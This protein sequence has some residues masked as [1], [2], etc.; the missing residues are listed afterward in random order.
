MQIFTQS[1]LDPVL[2]KG[3]YSTIINPDLNSMKLKQIR[4]SFI[5]FRSSSKPGALEG[6]AND[7]LILDEYDRVPQAAEASAL[8]GM[9]SSPYK[10]TN[11][12]STPSINDVGIHKLFKQSDQNYYMHKCPHCNY[13]NKMSFEP[14]VPEAPVEK[15]GNV[16]TVNP[17][18]V[19]LSAKT[20]VDGSFQYVCQKCGRPLDRW[21]TGEW[22]PMY[23]DRAKNNQGTRGYYIS[24]MNAVWI[25]LDDLK[26][27]ELTAESKQLFYNY[28]IG[29]PFIDAKMTVN[30]SDIMNHIRPDLNKQ[31]ENRQ[32]YAFVSVGVDFGNQ[33]SITIHGVRP[34]GVVDMIAN[35]QVAK[36]NPLNPDSIGTDIQALRVK[37]APYDPDIIVADIGDSGDKIAKL[38]QIYGKGKVYGCI[39]PS[40]PKS[41]GNV[42]PTWSENNNTV[43]ADKLMQNKRYIAKL[44][45]GEIGF[46]RGMDK[47]LEDFVSHWSNVVIRD[48]E[49][50]K[51]ITGFVQKITRKGPDHYSQAAIYSMLGYEY[52]MNVWDTDKSA[53][54]DS[55]WLNANLTPTQTDIFSQF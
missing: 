19:D 55:D 42:I 11:R 5:Y 24:Q 34:N 49:D 37:L 10:I 32:G 23:T 3:Y 48:E 36:A 17:Q 30:K 39:Y 33:H 53:Q 27:K 52:L 28:V 46:A 45:E 50:N 26:R 9:S 20:V 13:Y 44:K 6:L 38:I 40:T 25:S 47:S 41:S 21:M 31:P 29:E 7:Y 8:E 18:G 43:R 12:F 1:R 4:N 35:F 22:V 14:Y 51:S 54:F 16:L 2:N 15:R